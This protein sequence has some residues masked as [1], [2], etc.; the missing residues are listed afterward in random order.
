VKP[1]FR[2]EGDRARSITRVIFVVPE[3]ANFPRGAG[4]PRRISPVRDAVQLPVHRGPP[5]DTKRSG[6]SRATIAATLPGFVVPVDEAECE[7]VICAIRREG[8]MPGDRSRDDPHTDELSM[9]GRFD[10]RVPRQRDGEPGRCRETRCA[11]QAPSPRSRDPVGSHR[12]Q[13]EAEDVG[14][15]AQAGRRRKRNPIQR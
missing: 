14:G 1:D 6:C 15:K 4:I 11:P 10:D 7:S 2:V 3:D 13:G 5:V 9:R 8:T 12:P